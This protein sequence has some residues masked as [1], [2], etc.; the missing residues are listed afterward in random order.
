MVSDFQRSV[1][2]VSSISVAV[3]GLCLPVFSLRAYGGGGGGAAAAAHLVFTII[4]V[5]WLKFY[6]TLDC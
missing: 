3:L 2:S 5:P 6:N 1:W 4:S